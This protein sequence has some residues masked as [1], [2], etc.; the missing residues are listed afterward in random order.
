VAAFVIP[1]IGSYFFI[2]HFTGVFLHSTDASYYLQQ[3][4][5]DSSSEYFSGSLTNLSLHESAQK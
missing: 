5:D 2:T 1:P 4:D 3:P